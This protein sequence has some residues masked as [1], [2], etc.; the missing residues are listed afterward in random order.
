MLWNFLHIHVTMSLSPTIWSF[1]KRRS[2]S[3]LSRENIQNRVGSCSKYT[4]WSLLKTC[5]RAWETA[6]LHDKYL[7]Y[8]GSNSSTLPVAK[9]FHVISPSFL[10]RVNTNSG[11]PFFYH[12]VVLSIWGRPL[13]TKITRLCHTYNMIALEVLQSM[14]ISHRHY[15]WITWSSSHKIFIQTHDWLNLFIKN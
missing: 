3:Y 12:D 14:K 10:Q 4:W 9:G 2:C 7:I 11:V 13:P 15:I 1:Q 5:Q 6:K 8:K